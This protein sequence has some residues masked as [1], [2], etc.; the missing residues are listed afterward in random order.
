MCEEPYSNRRRLSL[1]LLTHRI[2]HALHG[3]EYAGFLC[4]QQEKKWA[5]VGISGVVET[6]DQRR[7][8][9]IHSTSLFKENFSRAMVRIR[10]QI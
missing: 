3:M 2:F 5:L 1:N 9:V 4:P 10:S 8:A 7:F 6:S